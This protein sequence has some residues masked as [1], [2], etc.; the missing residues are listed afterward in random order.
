M[1]T[2][3]DNELLAMIRVIFKGPNS[4][5]LRKFI[6]FLYE[7]EDEVLTDEDWAAIQEGREDVAHGR[8]VS[9]EE[10]EKA[11]GL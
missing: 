4:N 11:R 8:V 2:L 1:E 5:T 9:L 3:L 7:Q 10:Y 6:E